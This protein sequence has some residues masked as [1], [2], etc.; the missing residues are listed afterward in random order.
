MKKFKTEQ[1]LKSAV[2]LG[3]LTVGMVGFGNNV[4]ANEVEWT[5][6][7]VDQVKADITK[8][9]S[10]Y[11][12]VWGDTLS[13]ISEATNISMDELQSANNI[14][15]KDVIFAGNT[16]H[17]TLGDRYTVTDATGQVVYSKVVTD[18]GK[19]DASKPLGNGDNATKPTEPTNPVDPAKPTEPTNPVNPTNPT[20]PT[21]PVDPT[22]PVNPTEPTN[23]VDPTEP[24]NPVD[25]AKPTN[26][27]KYV[28]VNVDTDGNVLNST[29]GYTFVSESTDNG[30]ITSTDPNGNTVTTFTTT[31]IWKK[32]APVETKKW[33]IWY[34]ADAGEDQSHNI[35]AG[36]SSYMY[37]TEQEAMIASEQYATQMMIAHGITG[38]YGYVYQGQ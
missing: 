32:D 28:T 14:T 11:L 15:D 27:N 26:E 5:A 6:R 18:E 7:T 35:V 9:S 20:E 19:N 33:A 34:T 3:L 25:P 22:N 37:A 29:A 10:S 13:V 38:N 4:S 2:L 17:F 12:I 31:R 1:F 24:T 21:N 30:V 8:D 16:I 36:N 23:P